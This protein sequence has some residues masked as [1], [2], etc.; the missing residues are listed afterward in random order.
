MRNEMKKKNKVLILLAYTLHFIFQ[1]DGKKDHYYTIRLYLVVKLLLYYYSDI[2]R[3]KSTTPPH[4][5]MFQ[6]VEK[7]Q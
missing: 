2:F 6:H 3:L 4:N 1:Y 5:I 7:I